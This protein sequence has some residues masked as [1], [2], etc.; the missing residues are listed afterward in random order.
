[1]HPGVRHFGAFLLWPPSRAVPLQPG[2]G[3]T[4]SSATVTF[5]AAARDW[6]DRS[7]YIQYRADKTTLFNSPALVS[8]PSVSVAGCD[9]ASWSSPDLADGSWFWQVAEA[10][11]KIGSGQA[12]V[13]PGLSASPVYAFTQ[14]SGALTRA[15]YEYENLG[16]PAGVAGLTRALYEYENLGVWFEA[17]GFTRALYEYENCEIWA[18]LAG[19]VRALYEYENCNSGELFPWVMAIVPDAQYPGGQVGIVGDGFGATQAAENSQVTLH[20][21]ALGVVAWSTRSPGLYPANGSA[22]LEPAIT[23]TLPSD[24]ASGLI[25]VEESY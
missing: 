4:N 1:M 5:E 3:A 25:I 19:I 11:F 10:G 20:G 2:P 17:A 9:T 14:S 18:L 22:P 16:I 13:D 23:V 15:L 6:L 8:S 24:A 12:L 21:A 7:G